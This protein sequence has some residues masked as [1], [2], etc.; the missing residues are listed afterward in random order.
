MTPSDAVS[1]PAD[2]NVLIGAP[3]E[4]P[5][6]VGV[7]SLTAAL[8]SISG[9]AE[10]HLPLVFTKDLPPPPRLVLAILPMDAGDSDDIRNRVAEAT[11]SDPRSS[12]LPIMIVT[13]PALA[14]AIQN[15]AVQVYPVASPEWSTRRGRGSS[16]YRV[17]IAVLISLA[18]LA[19]WELLKR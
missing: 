2:A 17:A 7:E 14:T 3:A 4:P 16:S 1:I 19:L 8:A 18:I 12:R 13:Q 10:A 11:K 15:C 9:I 5:P 6:T